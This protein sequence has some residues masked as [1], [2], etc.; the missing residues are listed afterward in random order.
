MKGITGLTDRE[1]LERATDIL[2][3]PNHWTQGMWALGDAYC[4]LGAVQVAQGYEQP[5][6]LC[7]DAQAIR[8]SERIVQTIREQYPNWQ[9]PLTTPMDELVDTGH[10]NVIVESFNDEHEHEEVVAVMEKTLVREDW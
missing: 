6:T 2:R 1:V 9:P 7:T 5:S 3:D 4:I 10:A 8:L